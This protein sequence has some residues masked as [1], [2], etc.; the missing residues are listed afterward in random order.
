MTSKSLSIKTARHPAENPEIIKV[1]KGTDQVACDGG[2]PV[3]GHPKT[4]YRFDGAD[5][6]DC[7]YCD[8]RFVRAT[9]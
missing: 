1:P 6:I 2:H 4:Y 3:L 5:Y 7:L 9:K 8:R